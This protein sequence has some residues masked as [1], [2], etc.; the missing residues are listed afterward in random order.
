MSKGTLPSV[1]ATTI[2]AWNNDQKQVALAYLFLFGRAPD[3]AGMNYWIG[4]TPGSSG[5]KTF[6]DAFRTL[7]NALGTSYFEPVNVPEGGGLYFFQDIY[8]HVLGRAVPD[9][10]NNLPSAPSGIQYWG[11]TLNEYSTPPRLAESTL[12]GKRARVCYDIYNILA[13]NPAPDDLAYNRFLILE[14]VVRAQLYYG[15]DLSY[16]T[17]ETITRMVVDTTT[18]FDDAMSVVTSRIIN[19]STPP[20]NQWFKNYTQSVIAAEA[21]VSRYDNFATN[22]TKIHKYLAWWNRNGDLLL[23]H[24]FLPASFASISSNTQ[25]CVISLHGGGWR[26]A[27]IERLQSYNT[28]LAGASAVPVVLAPAMRLSRYSYIFPAAYNDLEDFKALVEASAT[29][30]RINTAKISYFGESS[31]AHLVLL[32]GSK[33][34]AGRVFSLYAPVDLTNLTVSQYPGYDSSPADLRPYINYFTGEN[35]ADGSAGSNEIAASPYH[36]WSNAR[37]TVFQLWHGDHDGLVP[38]ANATSFQNHLNASSSGKIT[39]H[40][41]TNG[42]HGFDDPIDATNPTHA[43]R[44]EVVAAANAMF[45]A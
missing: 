39:V 41:V 18:S 28:L 9:E 21:I 20:T 6:V 1:F 17:S 22:N 10:L 36:Q 13:A 25:R 12:G 14:G 15:R 4:Q 43:T 32:L 42:V 44:N 30:L 11:K 2:P 26:G 37:T 5:S 3:T 31:G 29:M 7:H 27:T 40:I 24:A 23:A 38:V 45:T 35:C 8:V 34:N 33:V 19:N 16:Q